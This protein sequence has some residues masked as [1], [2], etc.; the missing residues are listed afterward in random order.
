MP[1]NRGENIKNDEREE[2]TAL[3]EPGTVPISTSPTG[4]TN[5][6]QGIG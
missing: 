3:T 6:S 2:C 1:E 5:N 4:K